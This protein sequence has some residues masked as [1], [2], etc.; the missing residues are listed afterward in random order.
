MLKTFAAIVCLALL[1]GR[2]ISGRGNAPPC[3]EGSSWVRLR[4]VL[5]VDDR[6]R[7]KCIRVLLWIRRQ[8]IEVRIPRGH[9]RDVKP[10][11]IVTPWIAGRIAEQARCDVAD[12]GTRVEL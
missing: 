9:V 7:R 1:V 12:F 2:W 6:E 11:V 8:R 5:H 4:D 3:E 10:H